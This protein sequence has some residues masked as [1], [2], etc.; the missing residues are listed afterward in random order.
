MGMAGHFVDEAGRSLG[1]MKLRETELRFQAEA[2]IVGQMDHTHR[3]PT[4]LL[5][6][7]VSADPGLVPVDRHEVEYRS[8][9]PG[10]NRA[11]PRP[12]SG[13][14]ERFSGPRGP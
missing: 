8:G 3:T 14:N 9:N 2:Q 12:K 7:L 1:E 10:F 6:D 13:E 11:G 4:E 5:R